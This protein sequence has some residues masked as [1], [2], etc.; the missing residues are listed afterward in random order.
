V[1]GFEVFWEALIF[2]SKVTI[3]LGRNMQNFFISRQGVEGSNGEGMSR[4]CG[5]GFG[6]KGGK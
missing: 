2:I 1:G 6:V 3:A 5:N 4:D